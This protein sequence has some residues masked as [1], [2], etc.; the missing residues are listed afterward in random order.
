MEGSLYWQAI[1]TRDRLGRFLADGTH[2]R[3]LRAKASVLHVS[4]QDA[5]KRLEGKDE[6]KWSLREIAQF[7]ATAE[8]FLHQHAGKVP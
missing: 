8:D 6:D 5:A 1:E 2:P 7:L 4:C 3:N